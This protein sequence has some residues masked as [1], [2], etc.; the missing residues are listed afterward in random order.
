MAG[1][2]GARTFTVMPEKEWV[3]L[4][5]D[6]HPWYPS[7]RVATRGIGEDW[8]NPLATIADEVREIVCRDAG[9]D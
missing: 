8:H 2:V 3:M 5:T 6:R 4:G 9:L 1:S 7:I